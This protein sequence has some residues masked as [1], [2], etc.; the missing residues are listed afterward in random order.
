VDGGNSTR[1][2]VVSTELVPRHEKWEKLPKV[3]KLQ[4][5]RLQ[6]GKL[7]LGKIAGRRFAG[8]KITGR[9]IAGWKIAG[10]KFAGRKITGRKIAGW[11]IAGRKITGR[12]IAGWEG[13]FTPAQDQ[14]DS[15][16]D[17]DATSAGVNRPSQP[18]IFQTCNFSAQM[19]C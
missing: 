1:S 2:S 5:G 6:I 15:T 8:R 13:R 9:K 12:K 16:L 14:T 18:A 7:Q 19:I 11:K 3:G 4:F 17:G 10:R